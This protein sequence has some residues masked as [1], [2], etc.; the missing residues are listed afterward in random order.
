MGTLQSIFITHSDTILHW[1][2][3]LLTLL[4][5]WGVRGRMKAGYVHDVLERAFSEVIASAR[6][7]YQTYVAALKD[8]NADG[9]ITPAEAAEARARAWRIF[10]NNIGTKGMTKLAKVLGVDVESWFG[11]KLEAAVHLLKTEGKATAPAARTAGVP[12]PLPPI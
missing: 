5:A 2:I 3:S 11:H 1:A 7:V 12:A 6:E 8:A 10:A 9:I 4:F